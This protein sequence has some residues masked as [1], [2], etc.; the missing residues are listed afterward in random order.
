VIYIDVLAAVLKEKSFC[1]V[2]LFGFI[3]AA[4]LLF[5]ALGA[6]PSFRIYM[7]L[8]G[9]IPLFIAAVPFFYARRLFKAIKLGKLVSATVESVAF[10]QNSQNTLD[11]IENGIAEGGFRLPEGQ[12]INFE[13]DQPWAKDIIVG[14]SVE[15]LVLSPRFSGVFPLGLL[16]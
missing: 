5:G 2:F 16:E 11:A 10:T 14:S 12:L 1:F 6:F 7:A 8:L 13:I 15:L 4:V 9:V 3:L